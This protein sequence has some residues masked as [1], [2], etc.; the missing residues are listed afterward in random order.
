[1][2]AQITP[3][4]R[5]LLDALPRTGRQVA[6]PVRAAAGGERAAWDERA[7]DSW[8]YVMP[9]QVR[10]EQQRRP[11]AGGYRVR[12]VRHSGPATPALHPAGRS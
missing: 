8:E 9:W 6:D 2:R 7:P 4:L 1:V 12:V 3:L 5:R 10:N 11:V